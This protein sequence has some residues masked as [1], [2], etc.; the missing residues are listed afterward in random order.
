MGKIIQKKKEVEKA[1][2]EFKQKIFKTIQIN[3]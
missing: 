1:F 2:D 3:D